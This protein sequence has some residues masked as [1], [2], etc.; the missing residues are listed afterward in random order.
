MLRAVETKAGWYCMPW[1]ARTGVEPEHGGRCCYCDRDIA[2][3]DRLKGW[4]VACVYCGLA[5]CELPLTEAEDFAPNV[6]FGS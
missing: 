6:P 3:P 4:H 5:R 1:H 2:V